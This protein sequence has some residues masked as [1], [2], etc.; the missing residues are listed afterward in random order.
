MNLIFGNADAWIVTQTVSAPATVNNGAGFAYV[1]GA[2]SV[3]AIPVLYSGATIATATVN[4][5]SPGCDASGSAQRTQP[6]AAPAAGTFTWTATFAKNST[7]PGPVAASALNTVNSY[8]FNAAASLACTALNGGGGEGATI[9]ASQYANTN[10]GPTATLAGGFAPG[11][12]VPAIRLDNRAPTGAALFSNAP[13]G[14][15]VRVG[16]WVND[17]VIFN[18]T[19]ASNPANGAIVTAATDPGVGG[20]SYASFVNGTPMGTAATLPES[21]INTTYTLSVAAS[22]ALGN[23]KPALTKTFG[24]DRTPP[25]LTATVQPTTGTFL[26]DPATGFSFTALDSAAAPGAPAG[27]FNLAGTPVSVTQSARNSAGTTWWCPATAA[28]Q[29][30]TVACASW[31]AGSQTFAAG[32]AFADNAGAPSAGNAYFTTTATVADQAGNVSIGPFTTNVFAIDRVAP[33]AVVGGLTFLPT[34]GVSQIGSVVATLA[35]QG[36]DIGAARMNLQYGAPF[37]GLFDANTAA[38]FAPTTPVGGATMWQPDVTITGFNAATLTTSVLFSTTI[39]PTLTAIGGATATSG[40]NLGAGTVNASLS[41]L[42]MFAI[43]RAGLASAPSLLHIAPSM[44]PAIT[45]MSNTGAN[46]AGP[47][48]WV[49]C[50]INGPCA[51]PFALPGAGTSLISK[52]GA[53]GNPSAVLLTAAAGGLTGVFNNPFSMVQFWAYDATPGATEGWRLRSESASTPTVVTDGAAAVPNGINWQ[54]SVTW[55]PDATT[56][57]DVAVAGTVYRVIAIG[58]GGSTQPAANQGVALSTPIGAVTITVLP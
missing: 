40:T 38:P 45:P 33:V 44:L 50:A 19:A 28:F 51:A 48:F 17:A 56:A 36:L 4:F 53:G 5:G 29:A 26:A 12:S 2:I 32:L 1:T 10:A 54:Y 35:T 57:P 11:T 7:A 22:D 21:P 31:A 39:N 58:I 20:I 42:N 43:N 25:I 3:S 14:I 52:T 37:F 16:S 46:G 24:V 49:I 27:L 55:V 8:E 6:L 15:P 13:F 34:L 41:A 30:S 23:S 47:A 9:A 18:A